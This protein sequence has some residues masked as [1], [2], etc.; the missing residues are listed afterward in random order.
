MSDFDPATSIRP[1]VFADVE[2]I[3]RL[4]KQHPEEL[5]PRPISDLVMNVDRFLV[6]ELDGRI[7]G[8]VSWLILPEVGVS[9]QH[10][11]EIA[12][13]AVDAEFKGAGIGR[14]LV[15]AAIEKLRPLR[16]SEIIVLKFTPGFFAKL[17]FEEVSKETLIHKIYIGCINCTRY[18]SPFTCPEVAM[19]IVLE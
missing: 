2:A 9:K 13:L 8:C 15:E 11:V 3:F 1:A 12:T 6:C 17:G 4:T 16:P 5:V 18:D 7:V 19:R 14:A 10:D